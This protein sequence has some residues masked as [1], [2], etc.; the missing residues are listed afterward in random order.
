M[1][2]V[3][4]Y[5]KEVGARFIT[6]NDYLPVLVSG[7]NNLISAKHIIYKASAQIKSTLIFLH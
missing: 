7:G 6:R 2:R 3:T 4:D 5:L 1:S